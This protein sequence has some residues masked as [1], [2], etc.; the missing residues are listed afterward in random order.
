MIARLRNA[1]ADVLER[2]AGALRTGGRPE[3][4]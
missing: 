1:L 3:E 2:M 4:R